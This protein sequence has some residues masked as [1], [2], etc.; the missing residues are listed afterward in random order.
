MVIPIYFIKKFSDNY[1]KDMFNLVFLDGGV[2]FEINLIVVADSTVDYLESF[3]SFM[4]NSMNDRRFVFTY[5]L[6]YNNLNAYI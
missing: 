2:Q 5:F 4:R 6:N 1:L 3:A